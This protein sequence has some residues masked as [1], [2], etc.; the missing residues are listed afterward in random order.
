MAD[1]TYIGVDLGGT[2][3]S[4][5]AVAGG[6]ITALERRSVPAQEEAEVVLERIVETIDAVFDATV[7]GLG[8]GVPSVVDVEDGVVRDVGNIPSWKEV[9]LKDALEERFGVAAWINNDANAF[10]LGEHTYGKA[11]GHR[12]AVGM[13]L[14][15]GLGTGVIIDG[16]LYNGANCAAGELGMIPYRGVLL[17][18]WCA[19]PY[20]HRQCGTSGEELQRRARD[21][22]RKALESWRSYGRELAEGVKIALYAFDPEILVFGGSISTAFDLFEPGLWEGLGTF[23]YPHVIDRLVITASELDNA[24]VLGAAA[25]CVASAQGAG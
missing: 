19:G 13:T 15:T 21:G 10:A 16:R 14:G 4:V 18:D 8:V 2:K 24:A 12:H 25:L 1:E 22:D 9:H 20:F 23:E 5:G 3:V 17:E 7:A 6:E 11:K